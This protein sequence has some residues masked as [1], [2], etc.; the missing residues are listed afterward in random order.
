MQDRYVI[1]ENASAV[2]QQNLS[3]QTAVRKHYIVYINNEM[4]FLTL[5]ATQCNYVSTE[6]SVSRRLV[7]AEWTSL[8]P[9]NCVVSDFS[10]VC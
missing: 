1:T 4:C 9:I 5:N 8:H 6:Q 2:F 3:I 10:A 7:I